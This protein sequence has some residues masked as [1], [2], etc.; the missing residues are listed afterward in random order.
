MNPD[1]QKLAEQLVG[2]RPVEMAEWAHR[3]K[4]ALVRSHLIDA[5]HAGYAAAAQEHRDATHAPKE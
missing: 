4:V 2:P 1:Y 3:A 5:F